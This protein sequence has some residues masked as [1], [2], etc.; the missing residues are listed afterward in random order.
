[1]TARWLDYTAVRI[2]AIYIVAG[3]LWILFSDA[4]V[5]SRVDTPE[6]FQRISAVKGWFFVLA[7]ACSS[8]LCLSV[9]FVVVAKQ[10]LCC[11]RRLHCGSCSSIKLSRMPFTASNRTVG[12]RL[13]TGARSD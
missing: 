10:R 1:M 9:N 4:A 2:A 11:G 6:A 3:V 5:V 13:G 8:T 12:L 7:A